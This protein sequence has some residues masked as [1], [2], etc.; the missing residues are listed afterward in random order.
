MN[1]KDSKEDLGG[2]EGQKGKRRWYNY[3]LKREKVIKKK[4]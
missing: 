4:T 3:T 1:L 2:L